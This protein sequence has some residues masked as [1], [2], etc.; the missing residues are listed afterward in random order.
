M[1]P[2]TLPATAPP[3]LTLNTSS[4][5]PPVRFSIPTKF[6]TALSVPTPAP[7]TF[8]VLTLS[9]PIS[10]SLPPPP[11]TVPLIEP[12]IAPVTLKPKM[13][14]PPRP[15]RFSMPVK[16]VMPTADPLF[17]PSMVHSVPRVGPTSVSVPAPPAMVTVMGSAASTVKTS[18][19]PWPSSAMLLTPCA[20][21]PKPCANPLMLRAIVRPSSIE[22]SGAARPTVAASA[23]LPSLAV[24]APPL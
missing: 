17:A 6:A 19:P 5:S 21:L 23:L 4:R 9:A 12:T 15:I 2:A 8:H 24:S 14:S 1:P 7:V 22:A 20:T 16:P 3:G 10:V 13:S 11:S 18:A